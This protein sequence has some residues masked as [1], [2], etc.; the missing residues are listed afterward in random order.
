MKR[1]EESWV[2]PRFPQ[3]Q[4][5]VGEWGWG[6]GAEGPPTKTAAQRKG[7]SY[8]GATH[9]P[10]GTCE[11]LA[12]NQDVE[13]S[14]PWWEWKLQGGEKVLYLKP[15]FGQN[16]RDPRGHTGTSLKCTFSTKRS[17]FFKVES[18]LK[19]SLQ[20]ALFSLN[21][22]TMDISLFPFSLIPFL[23]IVSTC[24]ING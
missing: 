16:G 3:S 2:C 15:G 8:K 24:A 13:R 19:R 6:T 20:S 21:K 17:T 7:R 9:G 1:R 12:R 5:G 18:Y 11:L 14:G 10:F 22:N 23:M 4:G